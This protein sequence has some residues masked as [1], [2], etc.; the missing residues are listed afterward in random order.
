ME[1]KLLTTLFLGVF[2]G[3]LDIAV[4]GPALPAIRAEFGVSQRSLAWLL[5]AYVLANLVGTPLLAKLSDRLGRRSVYLACVSLFALGSLWAILSPSWGQLIAARVVQGF[6]AG[7]IFPIASATIGDVIPMERRGRAMGMIGAMFGIAFLVGPIVGGL[8]LML[9]WHWI[10][11]LNLPLSGLVLWQAMRHIP[12]NRKPERKPF[13]FPGMA[14][15]AVSLLALASSLNLVDTHSL[16]ASLTSAPVLPLLVVTFVAS[17]LFFWVETKAQDPIIHPELLRISGIRVCMGLGLAIGLVQVA[18]TTFFPSFAAAAFQVAPAQASFMLIPL[19]LGI[20]VGSPTVGRILDKTGPRPLVIMGVAVLV[21]CFAV[22]ALVPPSLPVFYAASALLGLFMS[23]LQGPV[24]YACLHA[25]PPAERA[26]A[27]S[28]VTMNTS[29][30]SIAA[31]AAMGAITAGNPGLSGFSQAYLATAAGLLLAF[32]V[33]F[34]LPTKVKPAP[35]AE[36]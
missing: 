24:R 11:L 33:A 29:I 4:L 26:A 34:F 19:V 32:V 15:L 22:L 16:V 10:F 6:G 5:N 23:T 14:L 18:G 7:G 27:Q 17:G 21:A 13:D 3:A 12:D 2:L 20:T 36:G 8:C 1:R 30:G 31:A 25:A 9:S 35:L 28:L